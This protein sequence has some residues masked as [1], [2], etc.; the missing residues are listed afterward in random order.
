MGPEKRVAVRPPGLPVATVDLVME[1]LFGRMYQTAQYPVL[2]ALAAMV[3][4][5]GRKRDPVVDY[6]KTLK[7]GVNLPSSVFWNWTPT[8]EGAS[9]LQFNSLINDPAGRV[10]TAIQMFDVPLGYTFIAPKRKQKIFFKTLATNKLSGTF[11]CIETSVHGQHE[12]GQGEPGVYDWGS[13][14]GQIQL[15]KPN[16]P[17][18]RGLDFSS[19]V[20]KVDLID[21]RYM[22]DFMVPPSMFFAKNLA[23][24]MRYKTR[25]DL[26]VSL[27]ADKINVGVDWGALNLS[28]ELGGSADMDMTLI[29]EPVPDLPQH[30]MIARGEGSFQ[31]KKV[32]G[33]TLPTWSIFQRKVKI[34]GT[35]GPTHRVTWKVEQPPS[36]P[37][38]PDPYLD[39]LVRHG[40]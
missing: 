28:C 31:L 15:S 18:W 26:Q 10:D 12:L 3:N 5:A 22:G 24:H 29:D 20:V 38:P 14:G 4:F 8:Y 9:R 30:R 13:M 1:R 39:F 40:V 25:H 16:Q 36:T 17:L 37:S 33:I 19:I 32:G 7:F 35:K 6:L 23:K 34:V 21:V 11:G 27:R 2:C